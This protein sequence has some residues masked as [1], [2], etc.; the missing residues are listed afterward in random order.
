[1]CDIQP[2]LP[3][4]RISKVSVSSDLTT[5][6]VTDGDTGIVTTFVKT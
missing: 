6:A 4:H 3:R 1:M 2:G 5:V